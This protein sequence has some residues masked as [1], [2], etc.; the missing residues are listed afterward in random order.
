MAMKIFMGANRLRDGELAAPTGKNGKVNL[1][2]LNCFVIFALLD[3][4]SDSHFECGSGYGSSN[5]S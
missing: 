3:P 2:N 5:S 1:I 4:D